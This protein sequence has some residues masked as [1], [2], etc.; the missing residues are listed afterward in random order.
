[1]MMTRK[2]LISAVVGAAFTF[3]ATASAYAKSDNIETE[4]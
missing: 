1:M 2:T 3:G 4:S